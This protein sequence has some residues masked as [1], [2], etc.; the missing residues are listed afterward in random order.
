LFVFVIC[1]RVKGLGP[2]AK[3]LSNEQRAMSDEQRAKGL[4][5]EQ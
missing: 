1:L 3:D 2:R 5:I 4:S